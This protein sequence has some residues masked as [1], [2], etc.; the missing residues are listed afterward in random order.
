M[1][2]SY[3]YEFETPT[4]KAISTSKKKSR[5]VNFSTNIYSIKDLPK[6]VNGGKPK[7]SILAKLSSGLCLPI[8]KELKLSSV[9]SDKPFQVYFQPVRC[10]NQNIMG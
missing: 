4:L 5:S 7:T 1:T 9:T 6:F 2:S 10:Q 8:L 3:K